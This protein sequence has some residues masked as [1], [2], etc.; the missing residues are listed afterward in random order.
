MEVIM[1]ISDAIIDELLKDYKSPEDLLGEKDI[2][3]QLTKRLLEGAIQGDRLYLKSTTN[4]F[5]IKC[6]IKNVQTP[7]SSFRG[8]IYQIIE[9]CKSLCHLA[10]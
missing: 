1:A 8:R 2:V 3:K 9:L 4:V 5:Y 7:V 6:R 10:K